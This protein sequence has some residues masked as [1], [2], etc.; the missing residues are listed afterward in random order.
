MVIEPNKPTFGLRMIASMEAAKG[1]FALV[2]GF[3]LLWF[4]RHAWIRGIVESMRLERLFSLPTWV[5]LAFAY[6]ALRL[7]EAYG[8]WLARQWGEWLALLSG[9]LYIP[10]IVETIIKHGASPWNVSLLLFNV[11]LLAYL[12][13]VLAKTRRMRARHAPATGVDAALEAPAGG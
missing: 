4:P 8:L 11:A 1:S 5:L 13:F 3:G 10:F 6:A 9:A 7:V 2:L 12:G